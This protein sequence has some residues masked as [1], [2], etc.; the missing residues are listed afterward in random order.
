VKQIKEILHA[1]AKAFSLCALSPVLIKYYNAEEKKC[2]SFFIALNKQH[3]ASLCIHTR[4]HSQ[5][6]VTTIIGDS[7]SHSLT[8]AE[9]HEN[10]HS[11]SERNY[12]V[13]YMRIQNHD[14]LILETFLTSSFDDFVLCI[15]G[16]TLYPNFLHLLHTH[17]HSQTP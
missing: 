4:E 13:R 8:L 16:G 12:R 3:K 5:V 1:T 6:D 15:C 2:S 7:L 10:T 14:L 9:K 11:E 17:T